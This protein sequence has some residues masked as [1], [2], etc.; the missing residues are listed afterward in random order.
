MGKT[1]NASA[2]WERPQELVRK[3]GQ[4]LKM[5]DSLEQRV[6]SAAPGKGRQRPPGE[7]DGIAKPFPG[8]PAIMLRMYCRVSQASIIEI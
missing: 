1:E 2:V 5:N 3:L 7:K 4:F 6:L 8:R